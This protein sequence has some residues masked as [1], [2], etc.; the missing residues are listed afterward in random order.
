MQANLTL[1]LLSRKG[2]PDAMPASPADRTGEF[3]ARLEK[4]QRILFKVA[5]M[6]CRDRNDRQDLVQ[7]MLVQ[8]WRSYARFDERVRFSTWMYRIAV[9]VAI[10]HYR[11]EGRRVRDTVPLDEYGL[12]IVAADALFENE[13]DNMRALRQLIDGL[14]ELNRALIL[15]FLEG[16]S[17]E[18]IAGVV[19]ISASNVSTRINRLKTKLQIAFHELNAQK[20]GNTA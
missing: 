18:E 10:T 6:Y 2:H 15:L 9:N 5:Y 7:E 11:N 8:L 20:E 17:S 16:F 12:D 13:G 1:D 4:H 3:I 14:D 19:G